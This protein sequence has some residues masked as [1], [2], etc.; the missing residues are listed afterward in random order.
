MALVDRLPEDFAAG[1]LLCL[2]GVD[3]WIHVVLPP[4]FGLDPNS[5]SVT[6]EPVEGRGVRWQESSA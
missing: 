3:G 5:L 1:R 6:Y 4:I 2:E